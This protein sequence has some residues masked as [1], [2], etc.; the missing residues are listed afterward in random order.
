MN[1]SIPFAASLCVLTHF[2]NLQSDLASAVS[3]PVVGR[4]ELLA[5]LTG[6]AGGEG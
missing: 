6:G 2:T 4:D 5:R 1:T 3:D